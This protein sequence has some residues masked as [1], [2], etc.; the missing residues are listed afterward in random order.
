MWDHITRDKAGLPKEH[1]FAE[2]CQ[3][4]ASHRQSTAANSAATEHAE[5]KYHRLAVDI[6]KNDLTPA[7]KAN[8]LYRLGDSI[9][10]KQ[11]SLIS[12]LF[13]KNLGESRL[14]TYIF[15]HGVPDL[16]DES[17]QRKSY[18]PNA[19]V[20]IQRALLQNMLEE[21]MKWHASFLHYLVDLQKHPNTTIARNL[22]NLDMKEW[23]KERRSKTQ[24]TKRRLTQGAHLAALRD[25]RNRTFEDMSATE[26]QILEDYETRV[27]S[28]QLEKLRIQKR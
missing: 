6:L 1:S 22:S 18:N 7:Q 19:S 28:T 20:Q 16:L 8:P 5:S 4:I 15:E 11:R 14:M 13:R 21:Y 23:Q 3:I 25:S 27:T 17:R 26:Q 24:E 12:V 10:T 9:T 2:W